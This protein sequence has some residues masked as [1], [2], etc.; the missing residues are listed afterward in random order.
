MLFGSYLYMEYMKPYNWGQ[1][2]GI[3]QEFLKPYNCMR[4]ISSKIS[5]FKL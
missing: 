2:I 5:Y 4:I 1:I 3:R